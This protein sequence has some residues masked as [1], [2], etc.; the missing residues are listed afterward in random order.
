MHLKLN[1]LLKKYSIW[2]PELYTKQQLTV[3]KFAKQNSFHFSKDRPKKQQACTSFY[4]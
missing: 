2:G 4:K 3:T 1:W